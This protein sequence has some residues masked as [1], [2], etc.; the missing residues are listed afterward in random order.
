[1]GRRRKEGIMGGTFDPIHI[2]H[3]ILG[4]AA[5][6]Q[7]GLDTV[8]FM[9]SGN[10]PHKKHR[11]GRASDE[12]R[13]EMVRMAI[14]GNPHFSLSLME[15][16]EE[17]YTYTYH[18]LERL[19]E[20]HPDTDYYFI[21]GADSLRDFSTWMKP[22]RISDACTLVVAGRQTGERSRAFTG[23]AAVDAFSGDVSSG[24]TSSGITSAEDDLDRMINA[25]KEQFNARIVRLDTPNIDISSSTIRS[26]FREGRSIRYY[27]PDACLAYIS[28]RNIYGSC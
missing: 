8:W 16:E 21:I 1:M 7:L 9:P 10:P 27:V 11:E 17:G 2:G 25:A 4:E 14:S 3:L 13:A 23:D 6:E 20:K 24:D 5:Y 26:W 18:T 22:Q 28:S 12:Q 19:R 15:M